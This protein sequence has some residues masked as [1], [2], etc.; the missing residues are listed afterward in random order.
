LPGHVIGHT[1]RTAVPR[2][3]GPTRSPCAPLGR[4]LTAG[5]VTHPLGGNQ[6][7]GLV[8]HK[9]RQASLPLRIGGSL[10]GRR[11]DGCLFAAAGV[12]GIGTPSPHGPG[13]STSPGATSPAQTACCTTPV[14][15]WSTAR[16]TSR[17]SRRPVAGAAVAPSS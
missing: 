4:T 7:F 13:R 1:T 2:R 6:R 15:R 9:G 10:G 12:P 8:I 16:P 3:A 17:G 5:R 14:T 11:S